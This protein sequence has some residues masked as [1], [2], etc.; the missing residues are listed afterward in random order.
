MAAKVKVRAEK[1]NKEFGINIYI[2][3]YIKEINTQGSTEY[4]REIYPVF[5]NKL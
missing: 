1:E 5:C 4:H 3:L 2:L